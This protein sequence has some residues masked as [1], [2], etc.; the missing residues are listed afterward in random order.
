[1]V[2]WSANSNDRLLSPGLC[3]QKARYLI[4]QRL[5]KVDG[6]F[7]AAPSQERHLGFDARQGSCAVVR[8][9]WVVKDAV[10]DVA[11]S[12]RQTSRARCEVGG[13]FRES[14]ACVRVGVATAE[15]RHRGI[16]HDHR[17]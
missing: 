10:A 6:K 15:S 12:R 9:P 14:P 1:M 17:N 5:R 4:V 11:A 3:T 8:V 16:Y 2:G 13:P 7:R